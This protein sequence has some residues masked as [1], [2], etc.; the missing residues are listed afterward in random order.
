MQLPCKLG[1]TCTLIM[2]QYGTQ[3]WILPSNGLDICEFWK[4]NRNFYNKNNF[5]NTAILK[6]CTKSKDLIQ[7]KYEMEEVS[8]F[9]CDGTY[10]HTAAFA[11]MQ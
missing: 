5:V 8:T 1:Y 4:M 11:W 10:Y 2:I 9:P 6:H 3:Y 7:F